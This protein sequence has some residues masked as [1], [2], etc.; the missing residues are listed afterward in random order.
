LNGHVN[1]HA[2]RAAGHEVEHKCGNRQNENDEGQG[3]KG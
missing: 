3:H 1:L 2:T